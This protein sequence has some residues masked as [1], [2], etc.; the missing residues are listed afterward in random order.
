MDEDIFA[1]SVYGNEIYYGEEGIREIHGNYYRPD[2]AL[3]LLIEESDPVNTNQQDPNI[4]TYS[5]RGDI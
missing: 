3:L 4:A 1:I 5:Y 2:E